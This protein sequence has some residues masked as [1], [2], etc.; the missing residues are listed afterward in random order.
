MKMNKMILFLSFLMF[1]IENLSEAV[2][3]LTEFLKTAV[4]SAMT[5]MPDN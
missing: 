1:F 4:A 3:P 2:F 5:N